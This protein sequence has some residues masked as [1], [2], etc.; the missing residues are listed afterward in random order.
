MPEKVFLRV[1]LFTAI[2]WILLHVPTCILVLTTS[3]GVLPN[4][5]AAPAIPPMMNVRMEPMSL[6]G[7]PP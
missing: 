4:T 5:L 2:Y 1:F 7:S 6:D 3:T